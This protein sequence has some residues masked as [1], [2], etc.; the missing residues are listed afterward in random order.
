MSIGELTILILVGVLF[1]GLVNGRRY[2]RVAAIGLGLAVVLVALLC[3]RSGMFLAGRPPL[4][5]HDVIPYG[6]HGA[7]GHSVEAH[8]AQLAIV[9]VIFLMMLFAGVLALL[10][11]AV[12]A[13]VRSKHGGVVLAILMLP[14]GLLFFVVM[15]GLWGYS[16]VQTT[17][18]PVMVVGPPPPP[19]QVAYEPMTP[20]KV[21]PSTEMPPKPGM[22]PEGAVVAIQFDDPAVAPPTDEQLAAVAQMPTPVEAEPDTQQLPP[23]AVPPTDS[24]TAFSDGT[25]VDSNPEI[26]PRPSWVDEP[27]DSTNGVFR[28]KTLVGPYPDEAGCE[29]ALQAQVAQVYR[30]YITQRYGSKTAALVAPSTGVVLRTQLVHSHWLEPLESPSLGRM[31]QL[32]ALVEIDSAQQ[33]ELERQVQQAYSKR[34]AQV[35]LFGAGTVFSII[36]ALYACLK[37]DTLT[38]G[39]YAVALRL[40]TAVV[41]GAVIV[42]AALLS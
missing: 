21:E 10:V 26:K 13:L 28:V 24:A 3:L 11:L 40:G 4:T 2:G 5:L 1:V 37:L 35:V 38:K 15:A 6:G 9:P 27:A 25:V 8:G 31:W 14:L 36:G 18:T 42:T 39:Y 23:D 17:A 16:R 32:H 29:A 41:I 22:E 7:S 30:D 34:R 12:R 19:R 33:A 20:F